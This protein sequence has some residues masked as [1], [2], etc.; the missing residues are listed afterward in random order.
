[1]LDT[2][3]RLLATAIERTVQQRGDKRF[4]GQVLGERPWLGEDQQRAVRHLVGGRDRIV[5]MEARAGRGKTT[6]T[7]A[8]VNDAYLRGC[9]R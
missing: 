3:R 9:P 8:A 1:M 2:E 7:L 5:L 6:T 4:T